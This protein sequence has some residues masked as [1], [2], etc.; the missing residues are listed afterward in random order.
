MS[1]T[2]SE[3]SWGV[4]YFSTLHSDALDKYIDQHQKDGGKEDQPKHKRPWYN[5]YDK[6]ELNAIAVQVK[7]SMTKD[8]SSKNKRKRSDND[9]N[10][11]D[12][13]TDVEKRYNLNF[14]TLSI[15]SDEEWILY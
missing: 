6:Q 13:D 3:K 2:L 7:E 4:P 12:T 5:K 9:K 14:D 11:I 8:S 10:S 15:D 1:P